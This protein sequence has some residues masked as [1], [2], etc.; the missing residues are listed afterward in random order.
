MHRPRPASLFR[1]QNVGNREA[2]VRD[3]RRLSIQ[4]A[5]AHH[6]LHPKNATRRVPMVEE[7]KNVSWMVSPT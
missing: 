1:I 4:C 2:N 6:H 3:P 5:A 7:A